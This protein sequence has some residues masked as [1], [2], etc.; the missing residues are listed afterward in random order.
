MSLP[1]ITFSKN[2]NAEFYKTLQQRVREYFKEDNISRYANA[3]MVIKTIFMISLYVV[4]FIL[5]VTLIDTPWIA[6]SMYVI[7]GFG[8]AGVGLSIM[9]DA[10][11]G[12]YS[13]N[14]R[15]NKLLGLVINGVGGSDVNWRIQHNVLHHTYTNV[16]GMDEDINPGIV[17]RF[18]PHEKRMKLHKYQH[19][20]A[21]FFYGLMTF[22]WCTTKDFIQ[23][24]RFKK[25]DLLKTQNITYASLLRNIIITKV[26]YFS[27]IFTLPILFSALPLYAIILGFFLMH[28]IAGVVL[29][30]IFQ[31]AHVIPS[32][33]YPVPDNSGV[34]DADWAVNQIYNT[35]NFAPGSSWFSWY[36]G[37]LNFQVEHHLFPNISHVHYKALSKIVKE[38]TSEYNLPY[39]S[40]KTFY[41]AIREHTKMLRD[42]GTKDFAPGIH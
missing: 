26:F 28:F 16:S 29:A 24:K 12:S 38:T 31:P 32:S 33:T 22:M 35:A 1:T 27:I 10:N 30:A 2:H 9:H 41:G 18:S 15:V 17:M 11:H 20:Y 39:F 23:A 7:M 13:K 37:G 40:F 8:M 3:S 34:V 21:W 6:F 5:M 42:L 19:I 4:P 25:Y 36:V 14:E